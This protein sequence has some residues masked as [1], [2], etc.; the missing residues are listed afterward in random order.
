MNNTDEFDR[1]CRNR[2]EAS[3]CPNLAK[4][5]MLHPFQGVFNLSSTAPGDFEFSSP[6]ITRAANDAFLVESGMLPIVLE[7]TDGFSGRLLVS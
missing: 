6:T 2:A 3:L 4:K 1:N 7:N 5:V